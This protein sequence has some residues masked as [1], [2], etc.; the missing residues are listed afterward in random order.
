MQAFLH[1]VSTALVVMLSL[2]YVFSFFEIG[3]KKKELPFVVLTLI[4]L[5]ALSMATGGKK[6]MWD[7]LAGPFFI[8]FL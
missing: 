6:H 3:F 5:V 8:F 1:V 2:G 7:F 4:A